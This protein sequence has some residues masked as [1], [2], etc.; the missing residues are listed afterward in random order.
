MQN[1]AFQL[2]IDERAIS[3]ARTFLRV[4]VDLLA[5]INEVDVNRVYELFRL[6]STYSYCTQ[7]LGLSEGAAYYFITVARKTREVPEL[8]LAIEQ[9][10]LTVSKAA[11]VASVLTPENQEE[12]I[13]KAATLTKNEIEKEVAKIAPEKAKRAQ[14]KPVGE[15]RE[16]LTVEL[17]DVCVAK[18]KRVRELESQRTSRAAKIDESLERALDAYLERNDPVKKAERSALKES[19]AKASRKLDARTKHQVMQR[20]RGECQEIIGGEKCRSQRWVDVHHITH[21]QD[22]GTNDLENL[23]TLCRCHH[24]QRHRAEAA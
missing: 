9:G 23:V 17:S 10:E 20:D 15:N 3:C 12:L 16:R 14:M 4:E 5:A 22:G 18:L 6:T 21:V 19:K 8:A 13:A 24:R 2:S 1:R 7:R 11:R